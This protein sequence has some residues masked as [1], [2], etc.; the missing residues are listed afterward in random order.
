MISIDSTAGKRR[1]E[2]AVVAGAGIMGHGIAQLLA[3]KG[4]HVRLVDR[5]DDLLIRA[6]GL[7]EENFSFMAELGELEQTEISG[8]L[9]R[10]V[11]TTD[12]VGNLHETDY[13][14]EAVTE[15]FQIKRA[16]WD[17][18]GKHAGAHTILASNTSSYDIDDLAEG[19]PNPGRV[20]GTHWFHP[21]QITPCVEVIPSR[22]ADPA[23]IDLIMGFLT[24]IGKVPTLCKS[25]PGFVANRIQMALAAE[26]LA[27]VEEGLATP[28]EVDRI[29]KTSFGF[30]LS[31]Y[32]PFEIIDQAGV[33]TY[34]SV[35]RYLFEK[36]KKPHFKPP[37]LLIEQAESG[38]LGL[39]TE[40]GFYDYSQ[41]AA[42]T[43]RRE[44]DRK[45]YARL[46]VHKKELKA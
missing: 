11:F 40:A 8:I 21:P 12:L 36:L 23:N 14:V 1:I 3:T 2:R 13:V 25:A 4:I 28:S 38:R 41:G 19:I 45:F 29:V 27:L 22:K 20:I 18:L 31:A 44:R 33:D 39:K 46:K 26:A 32:G 15:N 16:V 17:M 30:R 7:I 43:L 24:G 9:S 37:R 42:E 10:I 6:R 34:L 5:T 35:Y